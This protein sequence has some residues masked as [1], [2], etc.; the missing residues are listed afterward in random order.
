MGIE[1]THSSFILFRCSIL[2]QQSKQANKTDCPW[3]NE[4]QAEF[5]TEFSRGTE[6]GSPSTQEVE[7]EEFQVQGQPREGNSK[8]LSQEINKSEQNRKQPC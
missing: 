2:K 3:L 1:G 5:K 6:T 7:T 4:S 8:K